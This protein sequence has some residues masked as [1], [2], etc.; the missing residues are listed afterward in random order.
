MGANKPLLTRQ[1]MA[2]F[3]NENG[4]PLSQP[5]LNKLCAASVN[6]GPQ[7]KGWLGKRPLYAPDE[8][9]AWAQSMLTEGPSK[10]PL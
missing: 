9:L 10:L 6:R 8:A 4:F 2:A 5:T 3:L 1:Q 7:P